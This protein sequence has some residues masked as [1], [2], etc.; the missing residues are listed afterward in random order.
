MEHPRHHPRPTKPQKVGPSADP[1]HPQPK[2]AE[3]ESARL[4]ANDAKDFLKRDGF[5]DDEVRRLADEF[6]ALDEG[7]GVR[8]FVDWARR[9]ARTS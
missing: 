1:K 8:E 3:V 2:A 5:D 4:L 6:I 7:E 9:R